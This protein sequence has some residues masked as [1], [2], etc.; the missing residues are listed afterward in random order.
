MKLREYHITY[1]SVAREAGIIFESE[2]GASMQVRMGL[3]K[4]LRLGHDLTNIL[5]PT[6][7]DNQ[8]PRPRPANSSE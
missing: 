4:A 3:D 6:S 5:S 8:D 2:N 7:E 1:D